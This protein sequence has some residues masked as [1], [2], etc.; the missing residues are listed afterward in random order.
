MNRSI[1]AVI[2]G[3]ALAPSVMQALPDPIYVNYGALTIPPQVD[4]TTFVNYG[5]FGS[6]AVPMLF[7]Q[8]EPFETFDTL[9]F[10]N[11][12]QIYGA[13]TGI[14]FGYTSSQNGMRKWAAGFTNYNPGV[15]QMFDTANLSGNGGSVFGTCVVAPIYPG[16]MTIAASNI[17]TGAGTPTGGSSLAVGAGSELR[18]SGNYVNL[19][20]SGLQASPIAPIGGALFGNPVNSFTPDVAINDVYWVQNSFNQNYTLD[21]RFVWDGFFASALG[22]P[23]PPS[24]PI[25]APGFSI[26]PSAV[27]WYQFQLNAFDP[28]LID[29][30][31]NAYPY[32][33]V[34]NV[35]KGAV[36]VGTGPGMN[37][38]VG[39][40]GSPQPNNLFLTMG[41]QIS[42]TISN[43]VTGGQDPI[44][45][46]LTDTI[47]SDNRVRG[48][49]TNT[50]GC[51]TNTFRPANYILSRGLLGIGTPI[52]TTFP[53]SDFFNSSGQFFDPVLLQ[54]SCTNPVVA[55][56]DYAAYGATLDNIVARPLPVAGGTITNMPGRVIINA[57]TLDLTQTRIRADGLVSIT[58]KDLVSSSNAVI[59][60]ENLS[61]D[62]GSR[63]GSLKIHGLTPGNVVRF[64][65]NIEI[66][67][68]VWSNSTANVILQNY[69]PDTNIPPVCQLSNYTT[70]IPVEFE[71]LI[72]N[73]QAAAVS[74]PAT[75]YDFAAHSRDITV[76]DDLSVIQSLLIDGH[77][78]TLNGSLGL[79][80]VYPPNPFTL[81]S[82]PAQAV[83]NWNAAIAPN[84]EL[85]TNNGVLSI[86]NQGH[87]GDD[88]SPYTAFVNQGTLVAS[89]VGV[90]S[91]YLQENSLVTSAGPLTYQAQTAKFEN[92]NSTAASFARLIGFDHKFN[93]YQ[94][95]SGNGPLIFSVTNSLSDAGPASGNVFQTSSGFTLQNKPKVGDL[96]GTL[97]NT[98]APGT[99]FGSFVVHSWAGEDRGATPAGFSDNVAIGTL[100]LTTLNSGSILS[101]SGT[102]PRNAMYVDL[103]DLSSLQSNFLSQI[104]INPNLT[105]YYAA[106]RLPNAFTVP[107]SNGIPVEPEEYLDGRFAGHLRWVRDFAGPNSSTAV[108]VLDSSNNPVSI[109]VNSA[110][111]NS[112]IIDS[113]GDGL[114]NGSQGYGIGPAPQFSPPFSAAVLNVQ[115]NGNGTVTP[116]V[117][118]QLLLVGQRYQLTAH[119]ADGFKFAGWS[120]STNTTSPQIEFVMTNGLSFTAQF[121]FQLA[122]GSYSGLFYEDPPKP[123]AL[124]RSGA[125]TVTTTAKGKCSGTVSTA[126]ANY[127]FSG[128]LT[129]NGTLSLTIPKTTLQLNLLVGS[130]SVTGTI[131]N[132]TN[133]TASVLA[134]RSVFNAKTAKSPFAGKYTLVLPGS[135]DPNN[136][137]VPF[138]DSYA[139]VTVD[140]SG[141]VK[142]SGSLADGTPV[143][144]SAVVSADG[145][146]PL[147]I[148]LYRGAG[149]IIGWLNFEDTGSQDIGGLL[150][151]IKNA[152]VKSIF[153]PGGFTNFP[154]DA[155]GSVYSST[156]KPVTGFTLGSVTLTGG[157]LASDITSGITVSDL[158]KVTE[159]GTN[160]FKITLDV[161]NGFFKGTVPNP[162]TG[163]A[164]SLN[165]AILQ[166]QFRGS[167]YFLGTNQSGAVVIGP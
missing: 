143:S 120:G 135:G 161:K 123:V 157:N 127:K 37:A 84:L 9:N 153:Y 38:T 90:N 36:F 108:I 77:S 152:N 145:F 28:G 150:D 137:Q 91:D 72:V 78:F 35:I 1:L 21:G 47:G 30:N 15:V 118:G 16:S 110:L 18:L 109:Q 115:T 160:R 102:G 10:V 92:G 86:A 147:F 129:T 89:S 95:T 82:P 121:S 133:W 20:F 43:V 32:I 113:N 24:V 164:I 64:R 100:Q 76:D 94:L 117:T 75:V 44:F 128:T 14:R 99:T 144:Q 58:A 112:Q 7:S 3:L 158:N 50:V 122:P 57:D 101:F 154:S 42:T 106:A 148:P 71:A 124:L 63:S 146:W 23:Q 2:A 139:T 116:D 125:I 98:I 165:G 166:K 134:D 136:S 149:Q 19:S 27:G 61:F 81:L 40:N 49:I 79:P 156:N 51:G 103:L 55:A 41:V 87:F 5:S 65:G 131:S 83:Q 46:D 69:A 48:I 68:A 104:Q 162:Q 163:R 56:G 53:P 93:N 6:P 26:F 66:W 142:L 155:I 73:A 141:R 17:V 88:R 31:C 34:S 130:N 67:S 96:L 74:L 138:G 119:P 167:G 25:P 39:F 22:V 105:I 111:R 159:V 8:V 29:Q 60:C 12:G 4:A 114:P 140:T 97:I 70:T 11:Y 59:N 85:F 132:G 52:N 33:L 62:L 54:D 13:L 107:P 80:G 126:A 151:W 45:I